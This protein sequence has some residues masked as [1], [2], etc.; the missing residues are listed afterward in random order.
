MIILEKNIGEKK[1]NWKKWCDGVILNNLKLSVYTIRWLYIACDCEMIPI[2]TSQQ[3][4][5]RIYVYI[6]IYD[7]VWHS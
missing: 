3:D 7:L 4:T 2:V 6:G 1:C 5:M